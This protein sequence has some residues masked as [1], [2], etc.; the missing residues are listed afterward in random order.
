MNLAM[1][2]LSL[3]S[4]ARVIPDWPEVTYW[5]K[6]TLLIASFY[7]ASS[8]HRGDNWLLGWETKGIHGTLR[9]PMRSDNWGCWIPC[10]IKNVP[11]NFE[12]TKKSLQFLRQIVEDKTKNQAKSTEWTFDLTKKWRMHGVSR[13]KTWLSMLFF[14]WVTLIIEE[15][16]DL[17]ID[18]FQRCASSSFLRS[19]GRMEGL[20]RVEV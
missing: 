5:W 14:Y 2:D 4:W 11:S 7:E 19:V 10:K 1:L 15:D 16:L 3:P 20:E 6:A 12:V 8:I 17:P 18:R 13:L 9:A